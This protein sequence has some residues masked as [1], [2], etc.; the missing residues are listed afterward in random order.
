MAGKI[1]LESRFLAQ[2]KAKARKKGI[3]LTKKTRELKTKAQLIKAIRK[4]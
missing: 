3:C 2:I 1:P 4:R